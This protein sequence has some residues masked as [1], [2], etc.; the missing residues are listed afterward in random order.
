MRLQLHVAY[1]VFIRTIPVNQQSGDW[2]RGNNQA[3]Y[4]QPTVT[5]PSKNFSPHQPPAGRKKS[6][7]SKGG[8][9]TEASEENGRRFARCNTVEATQSGP[10][11]FI[12]IPHV[13]PAIGASV[14]T[15]TFP[16]QLQ[17]YNPPITSQWSTASPERLVYL[18]REEKVLLTSK[19]GFL[20]RFNQTQNA[21]L[22][23]K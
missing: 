23:K 5:T 18:C 1:F 15:G 16:I 14:A 19:C 11:K 2:V 8:V 17:H 9:K 10:A 21:W 13:H 4:S 12:S 3:R 20:C 22:P 7:A 6:G